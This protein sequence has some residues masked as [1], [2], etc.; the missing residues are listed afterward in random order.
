MK[1]DGKAARKAA[2]KP[3]GKFTARTIQ[4]PKK[5][6]TRSPL[7]PT[8]PMARMRVM[9]IADWIREATERRRERWSEE[10]RREAYLLGYADTKAG[11]P[12]L[13]Q[14]SEYNSLYPLGL[15]ASNIASSDSS[16]GK[17]T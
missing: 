6:L 17:D 1:A 12:P 5:G 11:L 15:T 14:G 4:I 3:S 2:G 7:I 16:T 13:P 8:T 9:L 10:G